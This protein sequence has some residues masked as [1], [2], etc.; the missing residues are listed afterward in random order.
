MIILQH[1]RQT[2]SRSRFYQII[3]TC[4]NPIDT[5]THMYLNKYYTSTLQIKHNTYV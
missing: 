5:I 3:K 2:G 1:M 4:W